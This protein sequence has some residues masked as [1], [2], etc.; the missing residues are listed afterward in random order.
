M[1]DVDHVDDDDQGDG[2]DRIDDRLAAI[3]QLVATMAADHDLTRRAL[4][5]AIALRMLAA[6]AADVMARVAVLADELEHA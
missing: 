3:T 2:P 1:S 5:R 6:L 4:R